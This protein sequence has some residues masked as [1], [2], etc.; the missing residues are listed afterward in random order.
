MNLLSEVASFFKDGGVFMYLIL[1]IAVLIAAIVIERTL[2]IVR[3]AAG[4]K[5]L[6]TEVLQCIGRGDLVN[7]RNLAMRSNSP[8]ARVAQAILTAG[9]ADEATLQQAADDAA[10][11]VLPQLSKR[12][13]GLSVLANSATL[14]GLLGTIFGLM[15]AFSGVSAADPAARSAFLAAGISQALNTTA[16]GL[17]VAV[18]TL[19]FQGYLSGQVEV[20]I[21]R[22]DEVT[23]RLSRAVAH[24]AAGHTGGQVAA[25]RPTAAPAAA[26]AARAPIAAREAGR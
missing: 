18:P 1:G 26:A 25:L 24:A 19:L 15:T 9:T 10:T 5:Q 21:G 20:I 12:L 13:P 14:L 4:A 3:A 22:V 7:A 8:V 17:I 6:A 16:F 2:V 23:I 11:L